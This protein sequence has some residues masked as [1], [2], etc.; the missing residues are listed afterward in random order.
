[1]IFSVKEQVRWNDTDADRQ[2]RPS[3]LLTYMQEAA[4]H[5]LDAVGN[6]FDALRDERGLA[7]ILTRLTLRFERPLHTLEAFT[8]ET[9]ISEGRGVNFP[10]FFRVSN[11]QGQTVAE[12]ASQWVL[13]RLD[14]HLPVRVQDFTYGFEPDEPLPFTPP[15]RLQATDVLEQVGTRRIVYSDIDYN[16]HMN[17]TRYPD[18]LCDFLPEGVTRRLRLM[19]LDFIQEAKFGSELCLWRGERPGEEGATVYFFRALNEA[20]ETC[21]E[22]EV[23]VGASE[24]GA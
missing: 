14:T 15:R 5:H 21:L 10:R 22:A 19:H 3:L 23:H 1:M 13:L 9:W 17:N 7:F 8:T 6:N 2:V 18:M 16:G 4:C 20:G 12:G 11:E 24:G